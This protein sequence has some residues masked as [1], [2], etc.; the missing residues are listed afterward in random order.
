[1]FPPKWRAGF[2]GSLPVKTGELKK[3]TQSLTQI[4]LKI[5]IEYSFCVLCG[6]SLR[7]LRLKVNFV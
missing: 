4:E 6:F 1:V 3:T 2:C 7:P 5:K